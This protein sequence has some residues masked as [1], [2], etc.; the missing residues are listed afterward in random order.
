LTNVALETRPFYARRLDARG[1]PVPWTLEDLEDYAAETGD[2][3][4]G[5]LA[6]DAPPP[7][8]SLQLEAC[9][10]PP[11]WL[12]LS[13][14]ELGAWS[15]VLEGLWMRYG[16]HRGDCVALF[17]YGSSPVVLLASSSYTAYLRRGAAE[18]LGVRVICNDGVAVLAERMLDIIERLRP[19]ALVLRRDVL[20]PMGAVF[21]TAG[22]SL[23]GSCRWIAV[24]EPE[25]IPDAA[26]IRRWS[27]SWSVPIHRWLR[28]DAGY[29]LAGECGR[30]DAFHFDP[31]FYR[32]EPVDGAVAITA[33]FA[34]TCPA[35]RYRVDGA[36]LDDGGCA[37]EPGAKTVRCR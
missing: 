11:L 10:D 20:A 32:V 34:T 15:R 19:A 8:F 28:A 27:R 25:G 37:A 23:A 9:D 30:C 29:L 2:P 35:V 14:R 12:A 22:V 18:R 26:E 5:R 3:F 33:R 6:P 24:T 7:L 31:R 13:G 16:I 36:E 17:D 21:D 4:G 1:R